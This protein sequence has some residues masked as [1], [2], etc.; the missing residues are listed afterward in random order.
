MDQL[1]SAVDAYEEQVVCVFVHRD[2]DTPDLQGEVEQQLQ[3][4]LRKAG[5]DQA[6]AIVPVEE[7]EAWWLLFPTATE[8]LKQSW[9]DTLKKQPGNVD[10]ISNPKHELIQRT[11]RNTKR[12]A[13]TEADSSKVAE[14]VAAAIQ[15]G[16]LPSGQSN[17]YNRFKS[18]VEACCD[19]VHNS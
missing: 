19:Y 9:S 13:Y 11:G 2:A 3:A 14:R 5:I 10:M 4:N 17:S 15:G 1:R 18:S 16:S 12:D 6:H 7:I 8:K